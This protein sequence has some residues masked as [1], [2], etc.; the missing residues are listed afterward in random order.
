MAELINSL[1]DLVRAVGGTPDSEIDRSEA[2]IVREFGEVYGSRLVM[3]VLDG[4]GVLSQDLIDLAVYELACECA[5]EIFYW[6]SHP[7]R[8]FVEI[9]EG[10]DDR[11]VHAVACYRDHVEPFTFIVGGASP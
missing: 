11:C 9:D 3:T 7:E 2:P 8:V 5:R 4:R 1:D 10:D 6:A